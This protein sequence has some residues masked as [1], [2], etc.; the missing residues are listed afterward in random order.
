[1]HYS[2]SF[3]HGRLDARR[4]LPGPLDAVANDVD[5]PTL[6]PGH[7]ARRKD[8]LE[9][10]NEPQTEVELQALH[11]SIIRGR[12]FGSGSWQRRT[13]KRLGLESLMRARGR[14]KKD[15]IK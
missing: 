7:V 5:R 15:T 14:P 9:W 2:Q 8:W 11:Q 13:A 10:V 12:P 3:S 4:L 1:M 6:T